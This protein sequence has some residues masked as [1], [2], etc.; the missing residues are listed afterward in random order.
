MKVK[1]WAGQ[2]FSNLQDSQDLLSHKLVF[3]GRAGQRFKNMVASQAEPG[4]QINFDT[5]NRSLSRSASRQK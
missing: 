2:G 1:M 3:T 5:N 4:R